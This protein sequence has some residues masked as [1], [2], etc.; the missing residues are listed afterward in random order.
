RRASPENWQRTIERMVSINK[1]Q[2]EVADARA[3]IKYLSDHNGLSP[4]EARPVA[5]EYERRLVD[6][7]YKED[8][9]T[10]D[11]C[12]GC[13]SFGRVMSERRTGDEWGLLIAMHRGYYPLTDNQPIANG[14]G[15]RRSRPVPTEPGPDG[16]PPDARQPM[17]KAITHLSKAFPLVTPE[18]SA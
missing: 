5:F 16:R 17:D 18:W 9:D 12:T 13:H 6:H 2:L 11:L 4:E 3:I 8:K 10:A 7:T 1:A 15:F 14:Q